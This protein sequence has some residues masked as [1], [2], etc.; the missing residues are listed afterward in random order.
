[1]DYKGPN[2][3]LDRI[4]QS[5]PLKLHLA[6]RLLPVLRGCLLAA[7]H[8]ALPV[9]LSRLNPSSGTAES[10]DGVLGKG[11][12]GPRGTRTLQDLLLARVRRQNESFLL[13]T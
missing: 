13:A 8:V 12:A 4:S 7:G 1:M 2:L 9:R 6:C 3:L 10:K 11:G 5:L